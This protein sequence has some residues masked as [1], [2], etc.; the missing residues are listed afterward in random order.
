MT[1][2][3]IDLAPGIVKE[4]TAYASEGRWIDGDHVRFRDGRPEKAKGWQNQGFSL[5]GTPK[6]TVTWQD[7]SGFRNIGIATSD[8]LYIVQGG[9]LNDVTPFRRSVAALSNGLTTTIGESTVVV[10][11]TGHGVSMTG[12]FVKFSNAS[13]AVG[14]L[15]IDGEYRVTELVDADGYKFDAGSAATSSATGPA[16][17]DVDYLVEPGN[18]DSVFGFG[19]GA[20]R[21]NRGTWNTPRTTGQGIQLEGAQWSLD[22]W[23]EDLLACLRN[24]KIYI[25][26]ATLGVT[27][28][29]VVISAAAPTANRF[30]LVSRPSRHLLAFGTED[31]I[32]DPGT[33]DD[34]LLRWCHRED[35][36][37]W[38]PT[39][40]NTAGSF[41]FSGAS[42]LVSAVITRREILVWTDVNVWQTS[43][44]GGEDVFGFN[45][46]G[47]ACGAIGLHAT[48]DIN[49]VV[50]WMGD[51]N[52]YL[53]DGLI[54]VLECPLHDFIFEN[55]DIVQG[56]SAFAGHNRA[57]NEAI[58]FYKDTTGAI[59][60]VAV[61]YIDGTWW[62]ATLSRTTWVDSGVLKNPIATSADGKIYDHEIGNSD[63]GQPLTA[64]IESGDID[65]GD[66]DAI[67]FIRKVVTDMNIKSGSATITIKARKYPNGAQVT[68]GPY[69]ITSTTE[70][71]NFRIR[72]RQISYRIESTGA[73]DDWRLGSPR[74]DIQEDGGQ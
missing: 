60:M 35:F 4:D 44:I 5:E 26:D 69:E 61:N 50:Y 55:I 45:Q 1:L 3:R 32:G 66:G 15:T 20:G 54:R 19:W 51:C 22:L 74:F 70:K 37:D 27:A 46:I 43:F 59:R 57:E 72:G 31:T 11:D 71:I 12:A 39:T 62:V 52:F 17:I 16:T 30:I 47:E 42:R 21:W 56:D 29:A 14:G 23:G 73:D 24:S 8:K 18:A 6:D 33:Q 28:R 64:F 2:R 10:A 41:R 13:G 7:L 38:V 58:W 40:T 25:H 9:D 53:Y 49:G 67:S 63:D 34:L 36:T 48:L 68:K 65:I